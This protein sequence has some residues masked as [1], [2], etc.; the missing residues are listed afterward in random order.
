MKAQKI[1]HIDSAGGAEA[2]LLIKMLTYDEDLAD[3]VLEYL[4]QWDYRDE[5]DEE[6]DLK[7]CEHEKF[8]EDPGDGKYIISYSQECGSFIALHFIASTEKEE[9]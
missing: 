4:Q 1:V 8:E 6:L 7:N 3:Y 5:E 2:D 9:I